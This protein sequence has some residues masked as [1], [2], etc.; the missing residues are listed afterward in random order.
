MGQ[1]D[2]GSNLAIWSMVII[3]ELSEDTFFSALVLQKFTLF[4][5][6]NRVQI[7]DAMVLHRLGSSLVPN[8]TMASW[9]SNPVPPRH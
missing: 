3:S 7:M 4:P 9:D 8:P 1:M 6:K 5:L 2:T